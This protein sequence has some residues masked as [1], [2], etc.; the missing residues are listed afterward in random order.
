[1]RLG[2]CYNNSTVQDFYFTAYPESES[3]RVEDQTI[4]KIIFLDRE[5]TGEYI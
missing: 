3:G 5:L 4:A 1:M 2:S